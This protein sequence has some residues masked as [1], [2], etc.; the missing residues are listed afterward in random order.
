MSKGI[1]F[2]VETTRVLDILAKEI[3]DS[4]LAL[5]RDNV[6]NAYDAVRMRFATSGKLKA[7]GHISITLDGEILTISDNGIGM[8]ETVLR[9]N[10]WKAGSSG[11]NSDEARKAGVVGTF[12]IGAM[13]NFGVCRRLT[14]ETR[15]LG[16]SELLRSVADRDSLRIAQE[17]ISF[18]R[19]RSKGEPGTAL[20]VILDANSLITP[21]QAKTYLN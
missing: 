16:S 18:E 5:L 6:Q 21:N 3:Y 13:A 20:T 17:C 10:F 4:P 14:V 12:G 2:Q 15:A 19:I 8:T 9:E 11:K 7:G 1:V